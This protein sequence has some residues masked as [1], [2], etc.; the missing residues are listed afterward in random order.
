MYNRT[1]TL[2]DPATLK[3][4]F[5]V[6]CSSMKL[7]SNACMMINTPCVKQLRNQMKCMKFLSL[8]M[9]TFLSLKSV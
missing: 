1:S 4:V 3:I 8:I 6:T 7:L 5:T 2:I 9:A